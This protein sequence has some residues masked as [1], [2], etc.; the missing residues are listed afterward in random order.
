MSINY[1]YAM[2][3]TDT[4]NAIYPLIITVAAKGSLFYVQFLFFYFQTM[5]IYLTVKAVYIVYLLA[6]LFIFVVLNK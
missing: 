3:S 6:M 2:K 1:N 4:C 5:Y